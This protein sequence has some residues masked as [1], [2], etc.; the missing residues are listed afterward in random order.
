MK[1]LVC[2]RFFVWIV[3]RPNCNAI[4]TLDIKCYYFCH[5]CGVFKLGQFSVTTCFIWMYC[6][7]YSKL[8][9]LSFK[10]S[11]DIRKL[12]IIVY[13]V[14]IKS[15][16]F[17]RLP[18]TQKMTVDVGYNILWVNLWLFFKAIYTVN[19]SWFNIKSNL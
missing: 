17:E 1:P 15:V 13:D 11:G 18:R 14:K 16:L 10:Y 19:A 6:T 8:N 5:L 12:I 3:M 4:S 9:N 7:F 2:V